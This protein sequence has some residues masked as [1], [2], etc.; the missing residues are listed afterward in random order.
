MPHFIH[1]GEL[2][3]SNLAEWVMML[4]QC[5]SFKSSH[6]WTTRTE[7]QTP[8]VGFSPNRIRETRKESLHAVHSL[9]S[10]GVARRDL[11]VPVNAPPPF[12]SE[13]NVLFNMTTLALSI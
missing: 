8:R 5:N 1:S 10:R 4:I 3:F 11:R 7:I 13:K 12:W 2:I 6:Q 9:L